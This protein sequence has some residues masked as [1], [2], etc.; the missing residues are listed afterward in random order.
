MITNVIRAITRNRQYNAGNY[1]NAL[2]K[3]NKL[4]DKLTRAI[5]RE[6]DRLKLAAFGDIQPE[7]IENPIAGVRAAILHDNSR[8][9]KALALASYEGG[10]WGAVRL[11]ASYDQAIANIMDFEECYGELQSQNQKLF[12][13]FALAEPKRVLNGHK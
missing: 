12:L 11:A 4:K 2:E 6:R 13:T 3:H 9:V 8:K 5:T 10:Y 1:A 7:A